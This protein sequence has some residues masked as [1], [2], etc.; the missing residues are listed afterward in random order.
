MSETEKSEKK[1]WRKKKVVKSKSSL[2]FK[3]NCL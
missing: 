1:F 2:Y 3:T